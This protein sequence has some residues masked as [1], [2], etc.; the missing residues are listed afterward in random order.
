MKDENRATQKTRDC[1]V[2]KLVDKYGNV[3]LKNKKPART[4]KNKE[5]TYHPKSREE[6]YAKHVQK[7]NKKGAKW[8]EKAARKEPAPSAK[9]APKGSAPVAAKAIPPQAI[10]AVPPQKAET[11]IKVYLRRPLLRKL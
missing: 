10:S 5:R 2:R 1:L 7:M 3:E 9:A 11:K 6:L 8:A 4:A